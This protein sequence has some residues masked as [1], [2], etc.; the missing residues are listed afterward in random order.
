[1]HLYGCK[2]WN[3]TSID[4]DKLFGEKYKRR[5]WK[6]PTSYK[7]I[8]DN[9]SLDCKMLLEQRIMT[10]TMK[11]VHCISLITYTDLSLIKMY[12]RR[13]R[14]FFQSKNVIQ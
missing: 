13:T 10:E 9:L 5:I 1:M 3:L 2:L 4:I 7:Y 14:S 11:V 6:I 8:V 12:A